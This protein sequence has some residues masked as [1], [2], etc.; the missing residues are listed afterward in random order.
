MSSVIYNSPIEVDFSSPGFVTILQLV[1]FDKCYGCELLTEF[2]QCDD[3]GQQL[4]VLNTEI[5]SD[6]LY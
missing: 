6:N 1:M 2:L 4:P 3:T 5:H